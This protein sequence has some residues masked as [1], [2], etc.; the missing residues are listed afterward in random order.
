MHAAGPGL[1][2]V[3]GLM[4][5][6]ALWAVYYI[7][8]ASPDS[9]ATLGDHRNLATLTATSNEGSSAIDGKQFFTANCQ[10]CHQATGAGLPGVFPPLAGSQWVTGDP[11]TL[12]RIVLHGV[13]GSITVSGTVYNGSMPDFGT[14]FGD[15]ELAAV[16]TFI[17]SKWGN[18]SPAVD[19]ALLA[20]VR[21]ESAQQTRPWA[22]EAELLE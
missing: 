21:K 13:T 6:L 15:A 7:F 9:M 10:A 3:L 11:E 22:G 14:R 16:L 5:A 20:R 4:V 17:R 19:A 1:G 8:S 2:I 18:D 12:A